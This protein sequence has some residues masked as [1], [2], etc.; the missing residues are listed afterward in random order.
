[1]H[2]VARVAAPPHLPARVTDLAPSP[3]QAQRVADDAVPPPA[4]PPTAGY[5]PA[6]EL[7]WPA[8]PRSAPD[9]TALDGQSLS[10]LPL[11]L[12]LFIDARGRVTAVEPLTLADDDRATWPVLRAMFLATAYSPGRRHGHDVASTLD[13]ALGVEHAPAD[14]TTALTPVAWQHAAA[15]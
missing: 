4:S 2:A 12:R 1:M 15:H 9:T 7:D 11:I 6:H 3:V 14:D 5:L 13:L 10:G 8:L